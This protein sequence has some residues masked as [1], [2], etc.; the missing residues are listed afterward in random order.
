MVIHVDG[1]SSQEMDDKVL[2]YF[3]SN[4]KFLIESVNIS[5]SVYIVNWTWDIFFTKQFYYFRNE[6]ILEFSHMSWGLGVPYYN[7]SYIINCNENVASVILM[8]GK[9]RKINTNGLYIFIFD[10]LVN[11]IEIEEFFRRAWSYSIL[12]I[13][14]IANKIIHIYNPFVIS[15]SESLPGKVYSFA[16]DKTEKIALI[17]KSRLENLHQYPLKVYKVNY[18]ELF[19]EEKSKAE[20]KNVESEV[21]MILQHCMNFKIKYVV[22]PDHYRMRQRL[23]N[24]TFAGNFF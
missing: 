6:N 20:Y 13:L 16:G 21:T 24:G 8:L 17:E 22:S 10:K 2:E 12:N 23:P 11:D 15:E 7:T 1:I 18:F 5:R 14:L 9:L 4:A 3:E 19:G